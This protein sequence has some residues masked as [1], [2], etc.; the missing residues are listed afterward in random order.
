MAGTRPPRREGLAAALLALLALSAVVAGVTGVGLADDADHVTRNGDTL[1]IRLTDEHFDGEAKAEEI[2]VAVEGVGEVVEP[3]DDGNATDTFE[4][5]VENVSTPG[6]DL[7]AANVTVK[8]DNGSVTEE[9]VDL[10]LLRFDAENATFVD[11]TLEVPLPTA[12]GYADGADAS[13]TLD[14]DAEPVDGRV[15]YG[16]DGAVLAVSF[17]AGQM[18]L[19]LSET[20]TIRAS[21]RFQTQVNL[22]E[23]AREA[24]EVTALD[25]ETL[26]VTHPFV[27]ADAEYDLVVE[28][29]NPN[30][31]FAGAVPADGNGS[32]ATTDAA[33]V[34]ADGWTVSAYRDGEALFEDHE[35]RPESDELVAA[36]VESNG[37]AVNLTDR[38]F[39]DDDA[40]VWLQNSSRLVQFSA[41]VENGSVT[42]AGTDYRLDETGSYRLLVAGDQ[43]VSA[44]VPGNESNDTLYAAVTDDGATNGADESEGALPG[45]VPGGWVGV[46]GLVSVFVLLVFGVVAVAGLKRRRSPPSSTASGTATTHRETPTVTVVMKDA[47]TGALLDG[48]VTAVSKSGSAG[49]SRTD[50]QTE[51]TD[52]RSSLTLGRGRWELEIE[53]NGVTAIRTIRVRGNKQ[54]PIELGPKTTRVA[55]TDEDGT[56]LSG[57]AV[58]CTPDEGERET[59]RTD[60]RGEVEIPVA[61]AASE[62][63]VSADHEKYEDDAA[64]VAFGDDAAVRESLTLRRMTGDLEVT[65]SVD[66]TPVA[67]LPVEIRPREEAI[68]ELGGGQAELASGE[69]GV[70]KFED[71]LV[72]RYEIRTT[73]PD[74]GDAFS[75]QSKRVRVRDDRQTSE[76]LDATFEYGL[77]RSQRDRIGSIRQ[78]VDALDS[79]TGRDVAIPRY[80]G[81]ALTALLDAVERASSQGHRFATAD[82]D[83]D[84]VVDALLDATEDAVGLVDD[85]MTTK[86]NTDLFGACVDMPDEQVEWQGSFDADALFELLSEDRTTQRQTVLERFREVDDRIDRE[87]TDLAVVSPAR[88][89]WDGVKEFVNSDRGDD[90]VRGAAVAFVA[91]GLLDAVD[92]LFDHEKLRER[93]QRTVF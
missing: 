76:T 19:P 38:S 24:T 7:S 12:L 2:T 30:G 52:G 37:T 72:G 75:V 61:L 20:A 56:S 53:S 31:T 80:Y 13:V 63:E 51:V 87:R 5:P 81:S 29:T 66:G 1:T 91:V 43:H 32:L 50:C 4:V 28:T 59:R 58:T 85:A 71:L 40:T 27:V 47:A 83:P 78:D 62:V 65:T 55:V 70:A 67:G 73:V 33:L 89:L 57:L 25:D 22:R 11:E 79:V 69:D 68:R 36:T 44:N 82:A 74:G 88:E 77:D 14:G 15:R 90:P 16:D 21:D 84:T 34:T 92:E 10:R 64:T 48:T 46:A 35:F 18:S 9:G 60:D 41:P 8:T 3:S 42:L 17:D 49:G 39:S 93:L 26:V 45:M 54:V 86:R 6:T 23:R